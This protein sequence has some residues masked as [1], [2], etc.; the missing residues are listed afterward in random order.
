MSNVIE[1]LKSLQRRI[2]DRNESDISSNYLQC[3]AIKQT[4]NL[5]SLDFYGDSE[6]ESYLD[7]L[8]TIAQAGIASHI[9][10]LI[11]QSPDVGANGTHHWNLEPLVNTEATFLQLETFWI[12]LNQPGDSNRSIIGAD[13]EEDG[14]LAKLLAKS[15][16]MRTLNVP[17]A[18]NAAF[19]S[20]GERPIRTL[21]ID[22]G[23][24]TQNFISNLAKSIC[25]PELHCLA[26][27]EYNETYM[28]EYAACCTSIDSYCELL[29]SQAFKKVERFI[30]RNPIYNDDV[31]KSLKKLNPNLNIVV[32]RC[33]DYSV[34]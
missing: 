32:F 25:F 33:S 4:N 7:L 1:V 16:K 23:Y 8:E 18:P 6:E 12:Q 17:S 27:G 14:I 15:P 5:F 26:W 21:N 28:S 34:Q 30:W 31:I 10:S 2:A 24:D 20:V 19:F 22:A 11:L 3:L 9:R 13:Y 29:Q